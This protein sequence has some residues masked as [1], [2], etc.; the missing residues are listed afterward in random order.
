MLPAGAVLGPYRMLIHALSRLED[1]E[2]ASRAS[3]FQF[4]GQDCDIRQ[5]GRRL[6]VG[7]ILEALLARLE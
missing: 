5:I 3:A 2:V 7:T 4:R 6:G 1:P